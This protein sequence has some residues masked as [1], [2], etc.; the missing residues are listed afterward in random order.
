MAFIVRIILSEH[1]LLVNFGRLWNSTFSAEDWVAINH[2]FVG[3][4]FSVK[5]SGLWKLEFSSYSRKG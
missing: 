5:T 1:F 2:C 3:T 4:T